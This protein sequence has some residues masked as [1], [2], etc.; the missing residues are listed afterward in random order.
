MEH[1]WLTIPQFCKLMH[2]NRSTFYRWEKLGVI[3]PEA[4]SREPGRHP[5]IDYARAFPD[6][7]AVLKGL[8]K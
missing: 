4:V 5:R 6:G 3:P 1:C 2:L 8:V 7:Y